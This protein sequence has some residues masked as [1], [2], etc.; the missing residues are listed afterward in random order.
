MKQF[1]AQVP[2]SPV[3]AGEGIPRRHIDFVDA[4]TGSPEGCLTLYDVFQHGLKITGDGPMVSN[5]TIH[6]TRYVMLT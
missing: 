3:V 5:T 2:N 6:Y 4:L 1:T